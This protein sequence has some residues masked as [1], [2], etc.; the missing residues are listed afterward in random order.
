MRSLA[1]R[2]PTCCF[3]G[4]APGTVGLNDLVLQRNS[5]VPTNA[6]TQITIA[7]DVY[8]SNIITFAVK[9]PGISA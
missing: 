8:R 5:D 4:L 2:L 1:A 6:Q 3:A 9:K 7:Q